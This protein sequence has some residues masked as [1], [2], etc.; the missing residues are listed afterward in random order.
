[1]S[2]RD[3]VTVDALQLLEESTQLDQHLASHVLAERIYGHVVDLIETGYDPIVV[4][5]AVKELHR[6]SRAAG[7]A[8]P[9][10]AFVEVLDELDAEYPGVSRDSGDVPINPC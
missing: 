5:D 2:T 3:S 1:M 4:R 6:R 10:D 8:I 9:R 7:Q